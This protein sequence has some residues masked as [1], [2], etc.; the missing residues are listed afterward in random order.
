MAP[1]NNNNID[2]P[3]MHREQAGASSDVN[4]NNRGAPWPMKKTRSIGR[5]VLLLKSAS[6]A[7]DLN[8]TD[9]QEFLR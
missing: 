6:G 7:T 8:L 1:K 9:V 3:E 2:D 4:V 5:R